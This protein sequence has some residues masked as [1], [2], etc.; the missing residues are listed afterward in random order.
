[1]AN[2]VRIG[3]NQIISSA[4]SQGVVSGEFA[5][6]NGLA[7]S[8]APMMSNL[9]P[10][11]ANLTSTGEV[12]LWGC[13]CNPMRLCE[14]ANLVAFSIEEAPCGSTALLHAPCYRHSRDGCDS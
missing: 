2:A 4:T 6:G 11:G 5:T 14:K 12:I 7:S 1:M 13:L 10:A 9:F 8:T 3:R